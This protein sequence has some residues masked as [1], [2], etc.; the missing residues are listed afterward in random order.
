M[1]GGIHA[2]EQPGGWAEKYIEKLSR[3]MEDIRGMEGRLSGQIND[4]NGRMTGQINELNG[5][6]TSQISEMNG[7]MTSQISDLN[8]R[9]NTM[10]D[11]FSAKL[12][13]NTRHINNLSITI[14]VIIGVEVI[15][16]V[17]AITSL[18]RN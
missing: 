5:R 2:P 7:R 16:A 3:D 17:I 18:I 15:S 9:M 11:R 4:L 14:A 10:I 12:D 1:A 6:M 13:D 8:G